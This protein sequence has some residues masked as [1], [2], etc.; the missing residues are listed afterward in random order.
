MTEAYL[1]YLGVN[2]PGED[3][4]DSGIAITQFPALV[5]R[6]PECEHRINNPLISRRHCLFFLQNGQVWVQDLRSSN[7][8]YLNGQRILDAQPLSEGDLLRLAFLPFQ[9]QLPTHLDTPA[10][11]PAPAPR[12]TKLSQQPR[13]VLVVE[14][15]ADAAESLAL[16][17]R[18][19]G[20]EVQ[21]ARTGPEALKVAEQRKPDSVV[22]DLRLP[23]M[24]GYQVARQ[25]RAQA[26]LEQVQVV[27][28]T[29]YGLEADDRRPEQVGIRHLLTKPVDPEALQTVLCSLN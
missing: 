10:V 27:A 4:L 28:I 11:K 16:L 8:T 23:G 12:T 1:H 7:G 19:W 24:D 6:Q 17:L 18:A 26:G 15:N 14:D 2:I 5:G 20:H 9:V 25:L 3:A 29:G 22:L 21:V 13:Q